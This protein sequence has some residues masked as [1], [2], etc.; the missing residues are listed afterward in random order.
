[1]SLKVLACLG[2]EPEFINPLPVGQLYFPTWERYRSAMHDIFEQEYYT[3]HGPMVQ[4]LEEKFA[5][6]L[7][8]KHVVCVTNATIGLMM[9]AEALELSG[10]VLT[11]AHTFVATPLSLT[12]CGLEPV[13][14]DV[15]LVTHHITPETLERAFVPDVSAVLGVHLWGSAANI[16]AIMEWAK[17]RN[18]KVYWDSAQA[19]GCSIQNQRIGGLVPIEVFSLHA[20][21]IVSA[22]EGGCITT[23]DSVLADKL[24]NIR[25]SYGV[26]KPVTVVK[27]ASGRMSEFQAA[28][29]L[30]S[31]ENYD[32]NVAH[33]VLLRRIYQ[34][35]LRGIPGVTL[36]PLHGVTESNQQSVVIRVDKK[37]F[38]VSRDELVKA[39]EAENILARRYF[40]PGAHRIDQFADFSQ[41]VLPNT[42]TLSQQILALPIGSRV[43][44]EDVQKICKLIEIIGIHGAKI[45]G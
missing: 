16:I 6:F 4:L 2:G 27:T 26:R 12:R 3:N 14:C 35:N 39:L 37:T 1:M 21:K 18:L 24:R 28:I 43:S 44:D 29:A 36:E 30:L 32:E 31:L 10:K 38:G 17:K 20:T 9:A 45:A 41:S 34:E 7:D 13:F 8:V 15:D 22:G 5:K 23:N 40:Y 33:N 19:V 11:P 25:S 42:D